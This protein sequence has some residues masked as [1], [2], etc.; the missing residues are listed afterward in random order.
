MVGVRGQ[1][2]IYAGMQVRQIFMG[3]YGGR[4]R[5]SWAGAQGQTLPCWAGVGGHFAGL[6]RMVR[7]VSGVRQIL[8]GWCAG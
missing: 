8:V 2:D 4:D 7:Q 6:V 5:L 1:T 3:W